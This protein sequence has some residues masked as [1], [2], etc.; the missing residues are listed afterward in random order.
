MERG[1]G[2]RAVERLAAQPC[3]RVDRAAR[4]DERRD[5]S[6]GVADSVAAVATFQ[7]HGLVEV[8]RA[9]WVDGEERQVGEV[10]RA[11]RQRLSSGPG[12]GF[13]RMGKGLGQPKLGPDLGEPGE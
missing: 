11:K 5:V 13:D 9:R 4:G 8:H 1:A 12:F 2:V 7:M 6:N 10:V 3:L